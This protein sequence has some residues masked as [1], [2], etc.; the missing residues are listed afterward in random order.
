VSAEVGELDR[1]ALAGALEEDP[2]AAVELLAD[3]ARATDVTL[4]RAARALAA[5]L[6]LPLARRGSDG[7]ARGV[8]RLHTV[9]GGGVELDVDA[10]V[11]RIAEGDG[12]PG[13]PVADGDQRGGDGHAGGRRRFGVDARDLR[14]RAWRQPGRAMVL[15]VDASGSVVGR[16]LATAVMT[17]AAL[18]SRLGA[19]DELAVI[20]FWSKAVV[21]RPID[22]ATP[23]ISVLDA[24]FDL[25]GGDTT[26]LAGGLRAALGEA[27][28]ARSAT[29]EVLVLTDGMA[30]AGNDP[31]ETATAAEASGAAVHVLGLSADP[32]ALDRCQALAAAGAGRFAP[33]HRPADAPRAVASI[34]D[35]L[36]QSSP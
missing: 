31:V 23:P 10:T 6:L 17:A 19:D 35:G 4:R 15:L 25:R 5:E 16:P 8:R 34:L 36:G 14:W 13:R 1:D 12:R 29:R 7:P 22:A 24:L 28:R 27:G 32:D 30:N 3:L 26:D 2:D 11:T 20:A 18:A 33:L 21:L 9:P